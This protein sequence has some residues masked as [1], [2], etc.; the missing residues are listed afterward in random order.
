MYKLKFLPEALEEWNKLD[1]SVKEPMRKALKK[2][3]ENPH[4]PAARLYGDLNSCYKIKLKKQGYRLIYYVEDEQLVVI[5][6][7]IDKRE[8]LKAYKSAL[9]RLK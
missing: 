5:V 3:I 6:V 2:R 9:C 8:D 4:V 1:G 7:A